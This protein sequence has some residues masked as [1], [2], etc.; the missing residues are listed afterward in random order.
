MNR[1][2]LSQEDRQRLDNIVYIGNVLSCCT[3][4][5]IH[6]L[7]CQFG[8][9]KRIKI[10]CEV[11]RDVRYPIGYAII[12]FV[13]NLGARSCKTTSKYVSFRDCL[14]HIH[15]QKPE[16]HFAASI[17]VFFS[18]DLITREFLMEFF[19]NLRPSDVTVKAPVT[20]DRLGFAIVEFP[21]PELRDLA[22]SL[23]EEAP[24]QIVAPSQDIID[25]W[26]TNHGTNEISFSP[27]VQAL[28]DTD[29]YRMF[30]DL[31]V[32]HCETPYRVNRFM[33]CCYSTRINQLVLSNSLLDRVE[34][35]LNI[36]GP[37]DL[38]ASTL[39]GQKIEIDPAR[40]EFV[41]LMAAD[42][43]MDDLMKAASGMIYAQMT[44]MTAIQLHH[45]LKHVDLSDG[46]H[47]RYMAAHIDEMR[48]HPE[49][50]GAPVQ[51]LSTVLHSKW[52]HTEKPDVF[53]EWLLGFVKQDQEERMKLLQYMIVEAMTGKAAISLVQDPSV[54]I[55][56]I[57]TPLLKF[58]Q[59]GGQVKDG[60]YEVIDCHQQEDRPDHG[61]FATLCE[62]CNGNPQDFGMV[63][64]S[65]N[66]TVEHVI[67]PGW[68]D[69]WS[70][71]S[72]PNSWICFD[73]KKY[74]IKPRAYS[75]RSMAADTKLPYL[76]SWKL[77]GSK[78]NMSWDLLDEQRK[79]VLKTEQRQ[80]RP[81]Q[82]DTVEQYRYL[83]LTQID[84]NASGN[85]CMF[86]Y[87]IEFFGELP[88]QKEN[89]RFEE[90]K[91]FSG[92][93]AY[94]TKCVQGNPASKGVIE[95]TTSSDP[96]YLLDSKWKGCWRSPKKDDS[97]VLIDMMDWRVTFDRYSLRTHYGPSHIQSWKVEVAGDDEKYIIVDQKT[98]RTEYKE[99]NQTH[100]WMCN[101]PYPD[102]V[103][104][105]KFTIT[106]QTK[107]GEI[108]FW[109]TN[110]E[111]FGNLFHPAKMAA[112]D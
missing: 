91:E 110:I 62:R 52:F 51:L 36:P 72:I 45:K 88:N 28:L 8:P 47:I 82:L 5:D 44:P 38:I 17:F 99:P 40:A 27:D 33:A 24:F 98:N 25:M 19:A 6:R 107:N 73:M 18:S 64:V 79:S 97:Y 58:L 70:T 42:F 12:E 68:Q 86:L 74:E 108:I 94:I 66:T 112:Q 80:W 41:F 7:F 2:N 87:G 84:R 89:I 26:G 67:E 11:F 104:Y 23:A 30:F 14:F 78:D 20:Y 106:G 101:Q 43:G 65:C 31:E 50:T 102:P 16:T 75:I 63:K 13:D 21:S 53:C 9:I 34:A 69:Y 59:Q 48:K 77:E 100:Y 49:F 57:R 85:F 55:N 96:K 60:E 54:N 71:P 15:Q 90:G 81:F 22:F 32:I 93:F 105:I 61:I 4:R 95:I 46:P 35:R 103:R 29:L 56:M 1:R 10:F 3:E 109:L 111:L 39:L 76:M 83:K 92:V 37:F